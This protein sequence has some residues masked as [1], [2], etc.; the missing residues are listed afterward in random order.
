MD[1]WIWEHE[2]M[3]IAEFVMNTYVVYEMLFV[4]INYV[5]RLIPEFIGRQIQ[6]TSLMSFYFLG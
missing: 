3:A 1:R 5:L 4:Q 6:T 2:I